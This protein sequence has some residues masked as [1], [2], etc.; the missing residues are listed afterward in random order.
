[1]FDIIIIGSGPA[2]MTSAIYGARMN[3]KVLV[4]EKGAPGGAMVNTYKI[5]NYPGFAS[6]DGATLSMNMFEQMTS[7]GVE[8][9]GDEV[10]KITKDGDIFTVKTTYSLYQGKTVILATGTKNRKIGAINEEKFLGRGISFCAICDGSL[11]K[12]KDVMVVGGGNS[13]IEEALYLAN[14]AKKVYLVHR[15]DSFRAALK[16]VDE[17]KKKENVEFILDS[18]LEEFSGDKKL[19][20]VLIKNLKT[21]KEEWIKVDGVFEYVGQIPNNEAFIDLGITNDNGY[22]LVDGNFETKIEGLFACGDIIEK[23]VRQI[24]TAVND[25]AISALSASRYIK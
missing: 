20:Q 3:L 11:Y 24:A 5:E 22:V 14:I 12:D 19:E 6:I 8:F 15:R 7:L 17:L 9:L 4:I 2:G 16:S 18:V 13:A 21:E 1:M 25:G 23:G 10:E